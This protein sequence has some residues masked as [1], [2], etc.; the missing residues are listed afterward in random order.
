VGPKLLL[1]RTSYRRGWQLPGGGIRRG[2]EP[3]VAAKRELLEEIGLVAHQLEPA[4]MVRGLWDYRHE[5]VHFFELRLA[6]TP[7]LRLDQREIV[8]ARFVSPRDLHEAPVYGPTAI[9]V[10]GLGL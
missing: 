7:R 4:G 10:H 1:V 5:R 8:E 9:Y 6:E 2:E 3:E